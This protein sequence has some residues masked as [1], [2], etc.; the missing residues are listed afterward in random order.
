MKSLGEPTAAVLPNISLD[1]A[2]EES[3]HACYFVTNRSLRHRPLLAFAPGFRRWKQR[4][5][6][7]RHDGGNHAQ[8]P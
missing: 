1:F 7:V 3:V 6:A 8:D 4:H 2:P 5:R